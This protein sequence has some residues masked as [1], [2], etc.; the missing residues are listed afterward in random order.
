MKK[1]LCLNQRG[2]RSSANNSAER[3]SA[4][5]CDVGTDT[6]RCKQTQILLLYTRGL[7]NDD[8]FFLT[9]DK[10][11]IFDWLNLMISEHQK[12]AKVACIWEKSYLEG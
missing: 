4:S 7:Q 6:K 8:F 11:L 9:T 10:S 1:H 5:K 3:D 2:S 12:G